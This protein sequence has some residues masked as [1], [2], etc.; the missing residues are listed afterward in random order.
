MLLSP[1]ERWNEQQ[2]DD[3]PLLPAEQHAG[4]AGHGRHE[5]LQ[6][7]DRLHGRRGHELPDAV[8]PVHAGQHEQRLC[9]QP[10]DGTGEW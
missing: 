6:R 8:Q 5:P 3:E 4:Y 10:D 9:R 7:P 2:H 1:G